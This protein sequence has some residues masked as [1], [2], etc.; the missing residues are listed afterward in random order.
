MMKIIRI[1]NNLFQENTYIIVDNLKNCIIIDPGSSYNDVIY[2]IERKGLN[3]VAILATHGHIDHV[4]GV[5]PLKDKYGLPFYMNF[6]D[7]ELSKS[8]KQYIPQLNIDFPKP[9]N[10]LVKGIY[11]FKKIRIKVI[12]TPGHTY[13]SVSILFNN[14]LFS[15]DTLFKGSIGRTDFGGDLDM[16]VESI[17]K[18]LF[19]LDKDIEV[20]PGHGDYTTIGYEINNNVYVGI[21]GIYSY[22]NI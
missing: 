12:E 14:K 18:K 20:Y 21:N 8:F 5:N 3:P 7:I 6:K 17:H 19:K 10:D 22:K 11:K 13:G 1:I 16:L 9:D 2:L 15:G 4:I